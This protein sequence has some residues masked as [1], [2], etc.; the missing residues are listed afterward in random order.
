MRAQVW[1]VHLKSVTTVI[2]ATAR[3][4]YILSGVSNSQSPMF[5]EFPIPEG[6]LCPLGLDRVCAVDAW[7]GE[8]VVADTREVHPLGLT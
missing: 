7:K 8:C 2:R 4:E 1:S 6:G 5:P 3:L